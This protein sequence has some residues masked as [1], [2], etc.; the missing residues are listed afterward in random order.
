MQ[1]VFINC[2]HWKC[3]GRMHTKYKKWLLLGKRI[4]PRGYGEGEV[5]KKTLT[6]TPYMSTL[7]E[8]LL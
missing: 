5:V 6:F 7:F 8:V 1:Y 2:M 4:E 3:S